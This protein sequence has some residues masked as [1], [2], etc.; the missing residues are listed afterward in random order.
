MVIWCNSIDEVPRAGEVFEARLADY[1]WAQHSQG[2]AM[3]GFEMLQ[4]SHGTVVH[5][6]DEKE[7]G[8]VDIKPEPRPYRLNAA[9]YNGITVA[10]DI[11]LCASFIRGPFIRSLRD[12]NYTRMALA[13]VLP[14]LARFPP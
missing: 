2:Q 1:A 11:F 6:T 7:E 5:L 12:G 9:L 8:V 14:F 4:P 3:D 13:A 10:L